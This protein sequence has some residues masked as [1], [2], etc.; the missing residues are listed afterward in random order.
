MLKQNKYKL[1]VCCTIFL[2]CSAT[3]ASLNT[4]K[5]NAYS[6][7]STPITN[8]VN[9]LK[10]VQNE[11]D[12]SISTFSVSAWA[13]MALNVSNND[14]NTVSKNNGPSLASY[15]VDNKGLVNTASAADV[16]RYIL[17]MT[18]CTK[19]P[20]A[21]TGTDFVAI[22]EGLANND[23][24]GDP[25]VVYDD[26]WGIMALVSAGV[27]TNSEVIQDSVDFIK[28][29]QA[30]DGGWGY[31]AAAAWGTD[32]DDTAA[33]I[34]ALMA[35]GEDPDQV[36]I[37]DAVA[38][39]QGLQ[40]VSTG[41]FDSWG[42]PNSASD[43]WV[44]GAIVSMGQHPGQWPLNGTSVLRHLLSLQNAGGSFNYTTDDAAYE[45]LYG[46]TVDHAW[47]TS[48]AIIA[49]SYNPYPVNVAAPTITLVGDFVEDF[50]EIND[51]DENA[52][53][54]ARLFYLLFGYYDSKYDLN[55]DAAIDGLDSDLF[56][57]IRAEYDSTS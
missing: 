1:L 36:C 24:L 33:A 40:N 41:A 6:G 52:L 53:Y 26:F 15:L 43:S 30:V 11:T 31:D 20:S 55:Q 12:G 23:Q 38:Y 28:N 17:A 18:A 29:C 44:M 21:V 45:A 16:S 2:L 48:Y 57:I 25:D 8:A 4:M 42:T 51:D 32:A 9:Y 3:F 27:S 7:T 10:S 46:I 39:L 5:A 47:F 56:D 54:I 19:D 50:G 22:L 34:M 14:P 49:L 13:A 35:A 37:D